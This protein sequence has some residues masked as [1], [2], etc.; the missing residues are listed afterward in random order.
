M[1]LSGAIILGVWLVYDFDPNQEPLTAAETGGMA[2]VVL[3]A[4]FTSV[5]LWGRFRK[6]RHSNID[7]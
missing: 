5:F 3:V 1:I 2:V 6:S 4:V 7:D